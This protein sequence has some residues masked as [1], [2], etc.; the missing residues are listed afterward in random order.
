YPAL[1]RWFS[2]LVCPRGN[3]LCVVLRDVTERT[4]AEREVRRKD[5]ELAE[6]HCSKDR[7]LVQLAHAVRDTLTPIRNAFHLIGAGELDSHLDTDDRKMSS[8]LQ[9][10]ACALAEQG[11]GRLGRLLDD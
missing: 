5:E 8:S 2:L 3:R 6:A 9:R 11:A 4:E 7:L 10:R 1:K